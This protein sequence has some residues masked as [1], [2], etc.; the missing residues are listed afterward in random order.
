MNHHTSTSY[1][2]MEHQPSSVTPLKQTS[3]KLPV[4]TSFCVEPT[5]AR[6]E[7]AENFTAKRRR[8]GESEPWT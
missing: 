5:G 6:Q 2:L 4:F 1:Q 3:H 8:Q 7:L